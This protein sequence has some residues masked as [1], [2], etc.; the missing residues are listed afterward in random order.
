V[1]AAFL[2]LNIGSSWSRTLRVKHRLRAIEKRVLR[3][4]FGPK[5]DEITGSGEDYIMSSFL[6]CIP[7]RILFG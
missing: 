3:K 6:I 5:M 4:T 1:S 7:Q 2:A